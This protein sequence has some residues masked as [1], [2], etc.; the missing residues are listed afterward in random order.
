MHTA[1]SEVGSFA[2]ATGA[3]FIA[4]LGDKSQLMAMTFTRWYRWQVVLAGIAITTAVIHLVSVA[5]GH[6][7][8]SLLTGS[9]VATI[10]GVAF[11]ACG[12]WTMRGDAINDDEVRRVRP[13]AVPAIF[14]IM[15]AFAL[16]EL[17]DKTMLATGTLATTHDWFIVWIGSTIGMVAADMVA[18][19]AGVLGA[20]FMQSSAVK[21]GAASLF[22]FFGASAIVNANFDLV[23]PG[24][25]I[26][27]GVATTIFVGCAWLRTSS[28]RTA[29]LEDS[30]FSAA[31]EWHTSTTKE[32]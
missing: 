22:V 13:T 30:A 31:D 5:V 18:V 12:V 15:S 8:P 27:A 16:A 20:R 25:A 3:V 19:A 9:W 29:S 17:G 32:L 26:A 24:V 28:R 1:M 14:V 4:E 21:F 6:F 2:V 7:L 10:A 23:G 11:I